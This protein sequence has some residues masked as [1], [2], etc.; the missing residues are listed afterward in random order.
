MTRRSR[1]ASGLVAVAAL[2]LSAL[3]VA[4]GPAFGAGAGYA[5]GGNPTVGGVPPALQ[6]RS[7][8]ARR[9]SRQGGPRLASSGRRR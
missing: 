1:M 9:F 8:L 7:S 3:S 2:T 4:A 6:E 5:P